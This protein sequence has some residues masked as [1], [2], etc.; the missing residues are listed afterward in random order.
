MCMGDFCMIKE[1]EQHT[2]RLV[3]ESVGRNLVDS[4]GRILDEPD[5]RPNLLFLHQRELGM[6]RPNK[7][8]LEQR[9]QY[10]CIAPNHTTYDLPVEFGFAKRFTPCG[11]YL[12][13]FDKEYKALQI[14]EVRYSCNQEA[15]LEDFLRLKW[16]LNLIQG[17]LGEAKICQDFC[18]FVHGRNC[19]MIAASRPVISLSRFEQHKT[20]HSLSPFPTVEDY[21]FWVIDYESGKIIDTLSIESDF[22]M[23]NHHIGVSQFGA[24][25]AL[26]S[27]QHQTIHMFEMDLGNK[28]IIRRCPIG[29]CYFSDD[30]SWSEGALV[31]I[32]Q[33]TVAFL[34]HIAMETGNVAQFHESLPFYLNLAIWKAQFIDVNHLLIKLGPSDQLQSSVKISE[35]PITHCLI[36][37]SIEEARVIDFYHDSQLD[38]L[39]ELCRDNHSQFRCPDQNEYGSELFFMSTSCNSAQERRLLSRT[40]EILACSKGS[41]IFLSLRKLASAIPYS[42]QSI[43]NPVSP[44]LDVELFTYDEKYVSPIDRIRTKPDTP[45]RI[46]SRSSGRLICQLDSNPCPRQSLSNG[47]FKKFTNWLFHPHL[48]L[49]ISVQMSITGITCN[50]HYYSS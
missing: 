45:I 17:E 39:F 46:F 12:I 37:W 38:E 15:Q 31:G 16:E 10:S 4:D 32:R 33:R 9:H 27:L 19:V 23:I 44:L 6:I 24:K 13:C 21:W 36:V 29:P 25:L 41:S 42:C 50:I 3:P 11:N 40:S 47:R 20:V 2:P 1:S 43:A 22:I 34:Y 5:E 26:T 8:T 7:R 28:K 49:V 35:S 14:Y 18:L 30:P 48:P